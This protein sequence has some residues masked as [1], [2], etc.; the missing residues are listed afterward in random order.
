MNVEEE[1]NSKK[2]VYVPVVNELTFGPLLM[3]KCRSRGCWDG[4]GGNGGS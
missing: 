2:E 4:P 1:N 3:V